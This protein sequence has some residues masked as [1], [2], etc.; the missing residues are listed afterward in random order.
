MFGGPPKPKL[1]LIKPEKV[2]QGFLKAKREYVESIF[3]YL[4]NIVQGFQA[5][6]KYAAEWDL[7]MSAD[8]RKEALKAIAEIL[9]YLTVQLRELNELKGTG[10]ILANSLFNATK[11]LIAQVETMKYVCETANFEKRGW[12]TAMEMF[13]KISQKATTAMNNIERAFEQGTDPEI[14]AKVMHDLR[15]TYL[16]DFDEELGKLRKK[17][18]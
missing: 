2:K 17:V 3:Y 8:N 14:K 12:G 4:N 11:D 10:N 18:S 5:L 1:R 7:H 13:E 9:D 6:L 15:K 16:N